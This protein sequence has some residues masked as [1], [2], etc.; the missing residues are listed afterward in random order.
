MAKYPQS[1]AARENMHM[2]RD[3]WLQQM[4]ILTEAV[5]DITTIDDYLI[6]SG[7]LDLLSELTIYI[8]SLFRESYVRKK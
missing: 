2:F 8:G 1:K 5:D 3:T 7:K 6:V 4:A